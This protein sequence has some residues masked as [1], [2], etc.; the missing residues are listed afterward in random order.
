MQVHN[1]VPISL[2]LLAL[3]HAAVPDSSTRED[4]Q[5]LPRAPTEREVF[6]LFNT[7]PEP[8]TTSE[9]RTLFPL[10]SALFIA[11]TATDGPLRIEVRHV[12]ADDHNLELRVLDYTKGQSAKPPPKYANAAAIKQGS[13]TLT[14][15][16]I[17]N[18]DT[19]EGPVQ[20]AL[21]ADTEYRSGPDNVG[22]LNTCHNMNARVMK[23]LGFT[24]TD[25]AVKF[26]ND[27]DEISTR[28]NKNS[29]TRKLNGI[30]LYNPGTGEGEPL[31]IVKSWSLQDLK[32]SRR[33]KRAGTC[34]PKLVPDKN[35]VDK[36]GQ[37]E[38]ALNSNTKDLPA[39]QLDVTASDKL[40]EK[41]IPQEGLSEKDRVAKVGLVRSG[42]TLTSFTSL[43]KAA[44][45]AL[46]IGGALVGAAFVILDFVNHNW[47]GG[48][49]GGVGVAAGLAA[50]LAI[51][52]PLGWIV[53]GVI[54]ALFASKFVGP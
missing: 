11:G 51:T 4:D 6:A 40:P 12:P 16:N 28:V 17:L 7:R 18:P 37:S 1:I 44:L 30:K 52:G 39:D 46:N 35:P 38:L 13:T 14:N 29:I 49:I 36:P 48:A 2:L 47:V 24:V 19:G 5:L 8:I 10:H 15:N 20:R 23:E 9:G 54:A 26:F 27:Y 34:L 43:S 50:G 33:A 32:C 21:A 42:G 45:S 22:K 25:D 53:G 41:S 31:K 3:A